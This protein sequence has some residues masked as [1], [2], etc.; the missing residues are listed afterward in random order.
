MKYESPLVKLQN[1]YA[2]HCDGDWEHTWGVKIDTLDNP[3][4]SIIIDLQDTNMEKVPF[5]G[6]I[7]ESPSDWIFCELNQ[8]RFSGR[9]GPRMLETMIDVF[10]MWTQQGQ[11]DGVAPI[12][13]NP[14]AETPGPR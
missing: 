14:V 7:I 3:G 11:A 6:L 8:G 2:S 4:W 12:V 10:L 1:W 5:P 13:V 9:C